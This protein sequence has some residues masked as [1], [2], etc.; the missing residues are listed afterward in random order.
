MEKKND[1]KKCGR[2]LVGFSSYFLNPSRSKSDVILF[3]SY[4]D[5]SISHVN[6]HLRNWD[7]LDFSLLFGCTDVHWLKKNIQN[8]LFEEKFHAESDPD[9][10]KIHKIY[11]R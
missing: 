5:F 7:V 11:Q 1:D 9:V 8:I 10:G 6:S 4:I 3:S 2:V